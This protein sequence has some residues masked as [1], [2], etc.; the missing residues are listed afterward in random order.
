MPRRGEFEANRKHRH[1]QT[2]EERVHKSKIRHDTTIIPEP[3]SHT[4]EGDEPRLEAALSGSTHVC[5]LS[6]SNSHA[7]KYRACYR[8]ATP[9][10]TKRASPM[11]N[12]PVPNVTAHGCS[13]SAGP[14]R[15][16]ASSGESRTKELNGF[17]TGTTL[18]PHRSSADPI[19]RDSAETETNQRKGA[20]T[21]LS[22]PPTP[23]RLMLNLPR[24]PFPSL[25]ASH[26]H[27]RAL[28]PTG[29]PSVVPSGAPAIRTSC[30]GDAAGKDFSQ[31]ADSASK[32][33]AKGRWRPT[34][35]ILR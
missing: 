11:R 14:G 29:P 9:A 32:A 24:S 23:P 4:P 21:R 25:A 35:L 8:L 2:G 3:G 34:P 16:S 15:F 26:C 1:R 7:P 6:R 19:S 28:S 12:S 30:Q 17:E 22:P 5:G 10:N 31:A 20:F 33:R 13:R 27:H 18:R